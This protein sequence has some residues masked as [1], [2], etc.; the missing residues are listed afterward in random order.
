[1]WYDLAREARRITRRYL[2][3]AIEVAV[4]MEKAYEAETGRD[5][6]KIKLDYGLEQPGACS[7]PMRCCSTST[8]SASTSCARSRRRRR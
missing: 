1:M 8:S 2:D 4:L 5:L 3:M 7:P 6:R